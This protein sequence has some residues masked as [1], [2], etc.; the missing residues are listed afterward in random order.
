MYLWKISKQQHQTTAFS[1]EGGLYASSRWHPQGWRIVYTASSLAR[2]TLEIFV[3]LESDR[4]P[5]IAIR[6]EI[7]SDIEIQAVKSQDLS[8]QWQQISSYPQLQEIGKK[9]LQTPSTAI[10]PVPSAI[11]PAEFN[12]LN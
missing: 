4:I 8:E 7:L 5:L 11:V 12:Y 9:W 6:A 3:H 2:A 1:G 10:P